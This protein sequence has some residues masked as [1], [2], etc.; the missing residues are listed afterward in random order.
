[1]FCF[2]GYYSNE[3]FVIDISVI[4]GALQRLILWKLIGNILAALQFF[5]LPFIVLKSQELQNTDTHILRDDWW[6]EAPDAAC[7]V[8]CACITRFNDLVGKVESNRKVR[9]LSALVPRVYAALRL[10]NRRNTYSHSG[11]CSFCVTFY[12]SNGKLET[13]KVPVQDWVW[14]FVSF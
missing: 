7:F 8:Q 9:S 12:F 5:R 2:N 11:R 10:W 1:M 3:P 14:V 4:I 6:Y 13:T